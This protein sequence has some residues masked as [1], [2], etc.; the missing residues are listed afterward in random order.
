MKAKRKRYDAQ[1]KA[2]IGF[3]AIRGIK[4]IQ[5]IAKENQ[6]HPTQVNQWKQTLLQEAC[7]LFDSK[8]ATQSQEDWEKER[9]RLHAKIGKQS[10]EIDWLAK[11]C[12]QL[13]L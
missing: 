8:H 12:E 1:F 6:I 11:K 3:E 10:V 5:Q 7:G 13:H 9:E 4:T 2:K